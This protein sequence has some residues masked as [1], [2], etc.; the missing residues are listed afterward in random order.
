MPL[1]LRFRWPVI[2]PILLG[3]LLLSAGWRAATAT[4]N[5]LRITYIN[6][7]Q[8]D[9][10]LIHGPDGFAVLID[11][12]PPA[13]APTVLAVLAA[14]GVTN[15]DLILASHNDADHIG[16]LVEILEASQPQVVAVWY[17][18]Y[19]TTS[20]LFTEFATAAAL[21]GA[22]LQSIQ[23]PASANWGAAQV[24]ILHPPPGMS[25]P[26][27]QNNASVVALVSYGSKK[28][29]FTGDL[30]AE[31]EAQILGRGAPLAAEALKIAHHGSDTST[32]LDFLL[33]VHP[34]DALISVGGNNSFGHP[35]PEVLQRLD[36]AGVEVWRTDQNGTIWLESDG[37]SRQLTAEFMHPVRLPLAYR[38]RCNPTG[39]GALP[40]TTI[41]YD[42]VVSSKEPDEYLEFAN[43][44]RC[45]IQLEG[46][47][48]RDAN[49]TVYTFPDFRI[50]PGQVCRLYTNQ[51][52]PEWCGFNWQRG[53]PVWSNAGEC[54][55]LWDDRGNLVSEYCY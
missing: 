7:G 25:E 48:A 44:D 6:V 45:P 32:T 1:P 12:G 21:D 23:Y 41:F 47:Q 52:H 8:G 38:N 49:N 34:T 26:F 30:E 16:G 42:G 36:A 17:N 24:S 19:P 20:D 4:G 53:S 50:A 15:L 10:A 9:S 14:Q 43:N 46:W 51:N 35:D 37:V 55:T 33:A 29:L 40:I 28:F 5:K 18:G 13:A 2:I 39:L 3:A 11:G 27:T 54:G 22:P 31:G